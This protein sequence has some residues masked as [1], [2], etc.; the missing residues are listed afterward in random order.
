MFWVTFVSPKTMKI[1]WP[2]SNLFNFS[3]PSATYNK[4]EKKEYLKMYFNS[5]E[6]KFS[7]K[8]IVRLAK[9]SYVTCETFYKKYYNS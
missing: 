2:L 7:L 1:V 9:Y 8:V 5:V 3:R 6:C 4:I